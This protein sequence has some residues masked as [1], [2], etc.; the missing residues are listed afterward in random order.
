[1]AVIAVTQAEAAE[2]LGVHVNTVAAMLGDGRLDPVTIGIPG[3]GPRRPVRR[4]NRASLEAAEDRILGPIAACSRC[5]R[6]TS[7]EE[8]RQRLVNTGRCGHCGG[9][10]VRL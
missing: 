6:H 1:M 5:R 2:R 8:A 4:V 9:D 10:L 7:R 3:A